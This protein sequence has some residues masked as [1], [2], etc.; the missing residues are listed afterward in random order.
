M[1]VN[2]E[3]KVDL[4]LGSTCEMYSVKTCLSSVL[5][6]N[7]IIDLDDPESIDK[8]VA[9]V[10]MT[11]IRDKVL[12]IRDITYRGSLLANMHVLRMCE[13][14]I[15]LHEIG[16]SFYDECF[17]LVCGKHFNLEETQE[18]LTSRKENLSDMKMALAVTYNQHF[19]KLQVFEDQIVDVLCNRKLSSFL[20][21]SAKTLET[22]LYVYLKANFEK[23]RIKLL[24]LRIKKLYPS[25]AQSKCSKLALHLFKLLSKTPTVWPSPIPK[26][27]KLE[28]LAVIVSR[29]FKK[30][31]FNF[32]ITI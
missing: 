13:E 3:R 12:S 26:Y 28:E 8:D 9:T 29:I 20:N 24:Q 11:S 18:P 30:R 22:N 15:T 23:I 1:K 27:Q 31:I 7:F 19:S 2:E 25:M 6:G 17:R 10:V 14:K 5:R 4:P 16:K 32:K 21:Y